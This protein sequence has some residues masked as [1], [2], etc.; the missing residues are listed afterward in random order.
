MT[1]ELRVGRWVDSADALDA[2]DAAVELVQLQRADEDRVV[3][4][5]DRLE[6]DDRPRPTVCAR[7]RAVRVLSV[8]SVEDDHDE[9]NSLQARVT[10]R[11]ALRMSVQGV[12]A[13]LTGACLAAL[14]VWIWARV[15]R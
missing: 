10:P 1:P 14:L 3:L 13:A 8:R 9:G 15:R 6:A 12:Y 2:I 7:S 5:L 11:P 4:A